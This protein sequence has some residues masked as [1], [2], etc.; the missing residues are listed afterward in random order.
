[1]VGLKDIRILR[2]SFF[3]LSINLGGG[4]DGNKLSLPLLRRGKRVINTTT[5]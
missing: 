3:S 1:M 4:K 2:I 5:L